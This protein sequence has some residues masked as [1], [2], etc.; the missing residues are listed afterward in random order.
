M[1]PAH[2]G[3]QP[4][5][6]TVER[7]E[8]ILAALPDDLMLNLK[9][10]TGRPGYGPQTLFRAYVATFI[11]NSSSIS[12]ALRT[13][14]DNPNLSKAIGGAPTK[15]ALSRF[16]SKLKDTDL[17]QRVMDT[18]SNSLKDLLPDLGKYVAMDSTDI[19]AWARRNTGS[20]PDAGTSV[21]ASTHGFKHYWYGFKTHLIADPIY[22][23]PLGAYVTPA[24]HSDNR[25]MEPSMPFAARFNPVYVLADAGYD[26]INNR[27]I[28]EAYNAIPIIKRNPRGHE[29]PKPSNE[30]KEIYA[31]R[32]GIERMFGRLK[33]FRRLNRLTMRGLDRVTIHC[34]TAVLTAMVWALAA[35]LLGHDDLIRCTV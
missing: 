28:V 21:K 8:A 10:A 3:Q 19:K 25:Q 24:N 12:A 35:L 22:E 31:H 9:A 13:I 4:Y 33:G 7:L 11:L 29:V 20:D 32:S 34:V 15:Y 17:L 27:A 30:W 26:S 5:Y 16:I 6:S 23:I 14:A 2:M 1:E 18:V